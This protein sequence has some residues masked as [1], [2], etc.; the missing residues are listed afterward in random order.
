MF[1]YVAGTLTNNG[2]ITMTA[3]GACAV[4]QN[5]YLRK[6]N[7]NQAY[8]TVPAVGANQMYNATSYN[9]SNKNRFVG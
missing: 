8:E 6:N 3:R 4:G 7:S 9:G 5:I 2:T 1:L